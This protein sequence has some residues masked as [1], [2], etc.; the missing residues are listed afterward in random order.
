MLP[1]E[2]RA[3]REL[4]AAARQLVEHWSRLGG[5]LGD[6]VGAMLRDGAD[7]AAELLGEL[8]AIA[9]RR[10]LFG[11][12]AAQGV[13]VSLAGARAG[14]ADRFLERNQALRLAV[15]DA[16]HLV[17]LLGYAERLA[18]SD[19][20]AELGAF[21]AGWGRRMREREDAAR[22]AAVASGDDPERAILPADRSVVGR[23]AHRVAEVAG[24]VGEII[25]RAR[26]K[27]GP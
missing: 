19:G 7:D 6:D 9:A 13:G 14:V 17:T 8:Q 10:D 1:A 23:T 25:D 2:H 27:T 16:T 26:A 15:L 11:D 12:L 3:L 22:A 24:S 4:F 21:C 18:A 20:D 5:R